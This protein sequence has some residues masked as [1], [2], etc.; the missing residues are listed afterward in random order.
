[1]IDI[2]CHIL[3]AIDDGP[4]DIEGS[5]SMARIAADDGISRIVASPHFKYDERPTIGDIRRSIAMLQ[6]KVKEQNIPVQL[7]CGADIRLTYELI[8]GIEKGDIPT[9]N[10]SRYFLLELPDLVPPNL[11]N[12][13]FSAE[14]RG[15]V[16]VITHPERNYSLLLSPEKIVALR[17]S[18]AL[19]QLTAMS[20]TGE[21]G[22]QVKSFSHMLLKKGYADFVASDAHGSRRRRPVLSKAY[23]EVSGILGKKNT[24]RIFFENPS[25]V[26]EDRPLKGHD[27]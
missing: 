25:A 26:I 18:G 19:F 12:F 1:V 23:R 3:P 15:L 16:P 7:L 27:L 9:V 4:G 11:D 8:N 10:E 20:V 22:S 13:L 17:G 5:I 24:E 2:H 21:F 6:E 14:L